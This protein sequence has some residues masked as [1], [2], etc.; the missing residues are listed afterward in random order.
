MGYDIIDIIWS[1]MFV[2]SFQPLSHLPMALGW[3][4]RKGVLALELQ[5]TA[6]SLPAQARLEE[7]HDNMP[8]G[9]PNGRTECVK[10][11]NCNYA[12]RN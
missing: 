4:L 3:W 8:H 5:H 9:M 7:R 1:H 11:C 12:S 10:Q 6:C 2:S